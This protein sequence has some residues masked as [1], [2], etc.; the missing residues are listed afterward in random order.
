MAVLAFKELYL[1]YGSVA[2]CHWGNA[3]FRYLDLQGP[4]HSIVFERTS[5]FFGI[6]Q[7]GDSFVG[8]AFATTVCRLPV[9]NAKLDDPNGYRAMDGAELL[10]LPSGDGLGNEYDISASPGGFCGVETWCQ[11]ARFSINDLSSGLITLQGRRLFCFG[12]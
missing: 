9:C 11:A 12:W 10:D 6:F 7:S 1:P 8:G 2:C 5:P 4:Y 3:V